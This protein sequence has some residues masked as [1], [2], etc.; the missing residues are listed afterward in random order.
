MACAVEAPFPSV[1]QRI[2]RPVRAAWWDLASTHSGLRH[3]GTRLKCTYAVGVRI[4][5][6]VGRW[7]SQARSAIALSCCRA[8]ESMCFQPV[9][10]C[11]DPVVASGALLFHAEAVAA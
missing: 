6:Q 7:Q 11:I 10:E 5:V 8:S 1:S 9:I 3:R 2:R 4:L